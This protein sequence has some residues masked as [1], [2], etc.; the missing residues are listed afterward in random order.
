[1]INHTGMSGLL[2]A[3]IERSEGGDGGSA[4][5]GTP[6]GD[7]TTGP[8]V[9]ERRSSGLE[10]SGRH[11]GGVGDT[12][13]DAMAKVLHERWLSE[14][15]KARSLESRLKESEVR[16]GDLEEVSREGEGARLLFMVLQLDA[17]VIC[18]SGHLLLLLLLL[19]V[20]RHGRWHDVEGFI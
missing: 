7:G 2:H 1:M 19:L 17:I 4:A 5:A 16:I 3:A 8:P 6:P 14:R 18:C 12:T 9:S 11:G 13:Q 15:K 10:S 20:L